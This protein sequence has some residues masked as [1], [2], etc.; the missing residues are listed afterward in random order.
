METKKD[1]IFY[2][3]LF[4]QVSYIASLASVIFSLRAVSSIALPGIL[5]GSV[6]YNKI[7]TGSLFNKRLI[8]PI[9]AGCL[10]FY[11]M[12][13]TG[14]LYTNNT[15]EGWRHIGLKIAIL[16]TPVALCSSNYLNAYSYKKIMHPYIYLLIVCMLYCLFVA[17]VNYYR[18]NAGVSAF[19]YHQLVSPVL[20]HAIH[21]SILTFAGLTYVLETF[22]K[23]NYFINYVVH[24]LITLLFLTFIVLL[25]S[26]LIIVFSIV[27][28]L[29]YILRVAFKKTN[30]KLIYTSILLGLAAIGIVFF[31]HNPISQRFDEIVSGDIK[32]ILKQEKFKPG[33]YFNGLQ[34]RILEWRFTGEILT[35]NDAWLTGVG[36]GDA[37]ALLDKKY[38][39]TNMYVGDPAKG[40]TGFLGYNTHNQFLESILQTGIFGLLAFGLI[41]YGMIWMAI[42]RKNYQVSGIITLILL[43]S[44]NESFLETQY[45]IFIAIFLPLFIYYG[46]EPA[47]SPSTATAVQ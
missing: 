9:L 41:A 10:L 15:E 28:L 43:Y 21:F 34:F 19:L 42:K 20:F 25:S 29:F 35:E 1:V 30:R 36:P 37:Q 46:T 3:S 12:Q 8:N 13:F 17:T 4:I 24:S 2:V 38:A 47:N 39:E 32:G 16:A 6:V 31:T 14:L 33:D 7:E 27:Y 23:K 5:A 18:N 40:A 22:R 44:F 45:G 11:L 26:K